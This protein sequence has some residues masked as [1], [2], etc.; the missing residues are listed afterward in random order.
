MVSV[1]SLFGEATVCM[2]LS[3]CMLGQNRQGTQA[4]DPGALL[5]QGQQL[6]LANR[7]AEAEVVLQQAMALAPGDSRI[8]T[9]L[10]EV[11]GRL[12]ESNEAVRLFRRVVAS[13]PASGEAHLNLA[14]SL[15]DA[16]DT[17]EAIRET[18]ESIRLD[19]GNARAHLN[20]ARL[21][22]DARRPAEAR[23]EFLRA[24]R[25][26]PADPQID[27]F[28]AVF[29]KDNHH[30]EA[31][32]PLL[33]KVVAHQPEYVRALLLLGNV[34]QQLGHVQEAIAMWRR[35]IAID[36]S[37]QEA[38]Y[39]LSQALRKS[40]PDEAAQLLERFNL[41][42]AE[43]Q[44]EE[45]VRELG[46]QAYAAMQHQ[47][48]QS[49]I[50][51]LQQAIDLCASCS[52]RAD[53]HQRLGLAECHRGNLAEGEHELRLALSLKPN[54]RETIAALQWVADQ[55]LQKQPEPHNP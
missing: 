46:N 10:A 54:D 53:L 36:A 23:S 45:R 13:Q 42:H 34:Q 29:E 37:S 12:G 22:A 31:A 38:V 20:R 40:N 19:P 33:A 52:L 39:S 18:E 32:V 51:T 43:R 6:A 7:L 41:L 16:G 14:L 47:E 8:A 21:L 49:A 15:A 26:H 9:L 5:Q 25:L 55:K 30:P 48:W 28:W 50:V 3:L 35:V 2:A 17:K 27:Y 11:K 44:K 24:E 4:V 1:R